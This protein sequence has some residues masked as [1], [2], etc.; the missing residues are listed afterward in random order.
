M[1]TS[2][3]RARVSVVFRGGSKS[4]KAII[5]LAGVSA[6]ANRTPS[7]T[8]LAGLSVRRRGESAGSGRVSAANADVDRFHIAHVFRH[9]SLTHSTVTVIHDGCYDKVNRAALDRTPP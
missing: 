8:V 4:R 5:P 7:W 6:L 9:R 3:Q 1:A 2:N